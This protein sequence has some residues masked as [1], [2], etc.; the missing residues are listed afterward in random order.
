RGGHME[1]SSGRDCSFLLGSFL[2]S[3]LTLLR[4]IRRYS[5]RCVITAST[6]HTCWSMFRIPALWTTDDRAPSENEITA[7]QQSAGN[8]KHQ[9]AMEMLR[10]YSRPWPAMRAMLD[11]FILTI[12]L[13]S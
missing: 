2:N 6:N 3:L 5:T 11:Q 8:G 13:I 7:P 4:C 12:D 10:N 1:Q 9:L